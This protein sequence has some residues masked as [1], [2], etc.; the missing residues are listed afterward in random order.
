MSFQRIFEM[1]RRQGMPL[2]VTDETGKEPVVVLPL[3]VYEAL[4]E[5]ESKPTPIREPLPTPVS[6][7]IPSPREEQSPK[8]EIS[9][10]ERF[11]VEALEDQENR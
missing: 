8:V 4:M 6:S 7:P 9:L 10:E 11:Y 5:G 1:V 2:V 3:E